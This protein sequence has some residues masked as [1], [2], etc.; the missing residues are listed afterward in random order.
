MLSCFPIILQYDL[1][2]RIQYST[3]VRLG[4]H[5]PSKR[6]NWMLSIS[7]YSLRSSVGYTW[8]DK[9]SPTMM[10]LSANTTSIY[11][12]QWTSATLAWTCL[13]ENEQR[14][15][16]QGSDLLY[17]Q[18]VCSSSTRSKG[19]PQLRFK[20]SCKRDLMNVHPYWHQHLGR[21][22]SRSAF[23]SWRHAVN[24]EIQR[25]ERQIKS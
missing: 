12:A 17:S 22:C 4:Q 20:D 23:L 2:I 15:H 3:A 21:H 10:S 18:L 1:D 7:D 14:T 16:P 24:Q 5:K 6:T 25:A 8:K 9:M 11:N 19:R 13:S